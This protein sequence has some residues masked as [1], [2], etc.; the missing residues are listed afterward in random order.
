MK[1]KGRKAEL[2]STAFDEMQK[3]IDLG[4]RK[5]MKNR[6]SIMIILPKI[7]ADANGVKGGDKVGV[8]METNGTLSVRK[9]RRKACP[10]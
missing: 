7:W 6:T 4:N 1:Q 5:V 8:I 2:K 3:P 10:K 9:S